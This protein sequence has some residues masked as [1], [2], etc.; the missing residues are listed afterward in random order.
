MENN[1]A[2]AI[3]AIIAGLGIFLV[4]FFAFIIFFI[5]CHWKIFT[6]AGQEGWKS[7]IPL[8]NLYVQLQIA[9][10]PTIWLLYFMIPFVNI[11]FGIKHVHGLSKAFGKDVGFTVGLI[12]LPIVFYPILAFGDAKYVYNENN[13]LINEIQEIK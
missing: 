1:D 12:L 5:V 10:Q 7:I 11:Y 3:A 6:K 2:G 9:K 8:Y 13:S 4:F